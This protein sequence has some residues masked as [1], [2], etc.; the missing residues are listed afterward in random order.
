L[1]KLNIEDYDHNIE[2]EEENS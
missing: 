1:Q 2:S